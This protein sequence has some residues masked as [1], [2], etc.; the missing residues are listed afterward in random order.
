MLNI[1]IIV[2]VMLQGKRRV[3]IRNAMILLPASIR[4]SEKHI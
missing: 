2:R 4:V 1:Y 3:N